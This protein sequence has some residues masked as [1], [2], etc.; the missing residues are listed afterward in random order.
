MTNRKLAPALGWL[1]RTAMSGDGGIPDGELIDRFVRSRDE[2]A[3]ELLVWRHER[4]VFGVCSRV[5]NDVHD[6]E[7]ACQA[8]FLVLARKARSIGRRESLPAWLYKVA[9][10]AALTARTARARL[11]QREVPLAAAGDLAQPDGADPVEC[12]ELRAVLDEEVSRLPEQFRTPTVLC[13]IAGKTVAQA[14]AHLGCPQGTVASRLARARERLRLRLV[15]RGLALPSGLTAL[16]LGAAA[17]ASAFD[18][19]VHTTIRLVKQAS[20]GAVP[21]TV[22]YLA[23]RVVNAMFLRKFLFGAA[24]TAMFA[25]LVLVGSVLVLQAAAQPLDDAAQNPPHDPQRA[26]QPAKAAPAPAVQ[27]A[28]PDPP[29]FA[30]FGGVL[31]PSGIADVASQI[32][33]PI[34]KVHVKEGVEV[35][36]DDLLCEIDDVTAKL[37]VEEAMAELAHAEARHKLA[38]LDLERAKKL[39]P[40]NLIAREEYEKMVS[41]AATTAASVR[42]A[43]VRVDAARQFLALTRIR[44]PIAGRVE[45]V[46][47]AVGKVFPPDG[48]ASF[49]RIVVVD[50]IAL[51]FEIDEKTYLRYQKVMR[52]GKEKDIEIHFTIAAAE[53]QG[54]PHKATL[55][56][57]RQTVDPATRTVTVR[58]TVPN[59]QRLLLPGMFVRVRMTF[60]PQREK[61]NP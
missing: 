27:A 36:R 16:I 5:L 57:V 12:Q 41:D 28:R 46:H 22:A 53:E 32:G 54:F 3:F 19:R 60:E 38:S 10:R 23:E 17:Q 49:A 14:A 45:Q 2:A 52:A 44:A 51:R 61:A 6:A 24:A 11:A 29:P 13:Y 48:G 50:P 56:T 40:S 21:A 37:K 47:A 7:E 39:L 58:A 26:P 4:L 20:G 18:A 30:D 15:S 43:Q 31:E 8:V 1:R 34:S 42:L 35:K 25:G 55:A 33:G 59:P 9:Y